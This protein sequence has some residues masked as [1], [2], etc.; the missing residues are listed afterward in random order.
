MVIHFKL[1]GTRKY[2][3][4]LCGYSGIG[5]EISEDIERATCKRCL[6]IAKNKHNI[7]KEGSDGS[8]NNR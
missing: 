7:I 3:Y 5:V 2:P 1:S 4:A 8:T 6:I